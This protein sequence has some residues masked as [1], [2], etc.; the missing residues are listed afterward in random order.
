MKPP[1]KN[2]PG[3]PQGKLPRAVSEEVVSRPAVRPPADEVETSAPVLPP[4]PPKRPSIFDGGALAKFAGAWTPGSIAAAIVA[5]IVALGGAAGIREIIGANAVVQRRLDEI[6]K[7]LGEKIDKKFEQ[8]IK[9]EQDARA[10]IT[11]DNTVTKQQLGQTVELVCQLN[12]GAPNE[13]WPCGDQRFN[14]PPKGNLAPKW[15]TARK[16]P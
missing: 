14:P 16:Y 4:R 10:A 11:T 9:T 6:E 8:H 7:N 5:I 12:D 15:T 3:F 1:P 2:V 13:S